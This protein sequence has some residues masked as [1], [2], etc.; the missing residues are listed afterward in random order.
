MSKHKKKPGPGDGK[1]AKRPTFRSRVTN[2]TDLLPSVD[3]RSTPARVMR[4]TYQ[5]MVSH[6]G[7]EHITEARR[8]LARRVACL[9][10]ELVNIECRFALIRVEGNTP[11]D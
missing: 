7:G 11:A 5:A 9:E 3:G 1:A 2:G 6:C 4:D 10:A 8:L